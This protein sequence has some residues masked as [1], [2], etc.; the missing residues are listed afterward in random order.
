VIVDQGGEDPYR[1]VTTALRLALAEK[2][3]L[4]PSELD[5][6]D[7]ETAAAALQRFVS[8]PIAPELLEQGAEGEAKG[9]NAPELMAYGVRQA[10]AYE[11]DVPPEQLQGI[12]LVGAAHA[13][14]RIRSRRLGLGPSGQT[15]VRG[16][17]EEDRPLIGRVLNESL[18]EQLDV[19]PEALNNLTPN[20]AAHI[21]AT[22]LALRRRARFPAL[23]PGAEPV[24]APDR[25]DLVARAVRDAIAQDSEL[26][27]RVLASLEPVAAAVLLGRFV[28]ARRMLDT[29]R[30]NMVFDELTEALR[31]SA[32]EMELEQEIARAQR[33]GGGRLTVAFIDVDALKT[34]N[35]TN[36]HGAGDKLLRVLVQTLRARLRSYDSIARWG[37]DEF[38][39]ILPQTGLDAARGIMGQVWTL[40][41]EASGQTFSYGLAALS[42]SGETVAQFVDR[43]DAALYERKRSGGAD[44][45]PT[46]A[47]QAA[48]KADAH[49][50]PPAVS[51]AGPLTRFGRWLRRLF[52]S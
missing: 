40:F 49:V 8:F 42:D 32:G 12:N 38:L 33:L 22:L 11:L 37:G 23:P 34:V 10:L 26:H 2:L 44:P 47:T 4:E 1:L 21:L 29:L 20:M 24:A 50:D 46:P 14:D 15:G 5:G 6:L 19:R 43:A 13:L 3:E 27:P 52:T 30:I 9:D 48:P 7:A 17:K 31:R 28:E 18:A 41:Q 45:V 36:G 16:P 39:V 35:D 25:R 51:A